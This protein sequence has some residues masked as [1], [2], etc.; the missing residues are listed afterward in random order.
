MHVKR[1]R[2]K[3]LDS[4]SGLRGHPQGTHLLCAPV[5]TNLSSGTTSLT[6]W[7]SLCFSILSLSAR[8]VGQEV[9]VCLCLVTAVPGCL[10]NV[11]HLLSLLR[12]VLVSS[13]KDVGQ[14][15][16]KQHLFR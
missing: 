7:H 9:S 13:G 4:P 10:A 6:T 14:S 11:Q 15:L 12:E 16:L 3:G 8:D 5:C 2:N 1:I